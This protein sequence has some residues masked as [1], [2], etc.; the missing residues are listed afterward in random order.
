MI[1]M[2]RTL[3]IKGATWTEDGDFQVRGDYVLVLSL[4]MLRTWAG[5][6]MLLLSLSENAHCASFLHSS[7]L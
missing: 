7:A 4:T 1:E 2:D 6:K 5:R 3:K